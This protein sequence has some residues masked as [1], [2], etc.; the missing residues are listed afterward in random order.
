MTEED[1]RHLAACRRPRTPRRP[2]RSRVVRLAAPRTTA[3]VARQGLRPPGAVA[4]DAAEV[5]Y[6]GPAL[7]DEASAPIEGYYD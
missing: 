6:E 1:E 2:A 5:R 3:D 4:P 7:Y